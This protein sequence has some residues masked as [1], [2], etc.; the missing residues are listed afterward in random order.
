MD[1]YN[2]GENISLVEDTINEVLQEIQKNSSANDDSPLKV[3]SIKPST[4]VRSLIQLATTQFNKNACLIVGH[5]PA[6][7]KVVSLGELVRLIGS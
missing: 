5:G 2:K 6:V 1:Q 4:K 3:I 7:G